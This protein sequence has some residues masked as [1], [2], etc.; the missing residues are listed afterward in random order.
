MFVQQYG[1]KLFAAKGKI[2]IQAQS[3]E[4]QMIADKN[5]AITS[6]NGTVEIT[7]REEILL[8]CGGSYIRINALGIESGTRGDIQFKADKHGYQ[9]P[10]SLP[11]VL[12]QLPNSVCKKCMEKAMHA[13]IGLSSPNM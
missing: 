9:G 1:M 5:M 7:A 8:K 2:D 13:S 6:A 12:P 4:M 3:D 11:A 10:A